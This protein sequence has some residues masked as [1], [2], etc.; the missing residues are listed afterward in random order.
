MVDAT[1]TRRRSVAA[2]VALAGLLA[3]PGDGAAKSSK[4]KKRHRRKH[5]KAKATCAE[6]CSAPC[7]LCFHRPVGPPLCGGGANG[8]CNAPCLS[9]SDCVGTGRPYCLSGYTDRLTNEFHPIDCPQG[10][11]RIC[12]DVFECG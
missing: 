4:H 3:R 1:L 11:P 12:Y 2:S 9:D 5:K 7:D 10:H 8:S 6:Q